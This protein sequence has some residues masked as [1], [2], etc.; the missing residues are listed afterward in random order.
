MAKARPGGKIWPLLTVCAGLVVWLAYGTSATSSLVAAARALAGQGQSLE[1]K[2]IT[3]E[4]APR[5]VIKDQYPSFSAVAI[6]AE[7]NMLVVTD[8][9]LFQILEYDRRANTPPQARLTEPKRIISGPNTRAEMICGVYIDPVTKEVYVLNNDTQN[10]LPVFSRDAR[11]NATPSRYL[12]APHGTFGIAVHEEK[13]EMFLTVQHQNSVYVYR[14]QASGD[15]KPLRVLVG[16]DTQ[17]EDPHGIALDTKNKLIFVSNFGN[18]QVRAPGSSGG[19]RSAGTYGKFELPSITV[20][21][22][23]ASGNTKPLWIIEGSQTMLNWPSHIALHEERQELF[24]ANDA[25]DSILVFR[26]SDKGNVAPVRMIK[27]PHTGIKN[28]P[29]ITLDVKNGEISVASMGTHAVLFFPVTA[30]GDVKPSR[31]IRGGPANQVALN[32]GNPGAVGYD[33]KRDQILVPN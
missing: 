30:N 12:A 6:N 14:K 28:P 33:T 13:Q 15:E 26:A 22:L 11:G 3:I 27:G 10:W 19:R 5:R 2:P 32:I 16:S 7:E 17:L 23:D 8:E 1:R 21:P 29:G 9:N 18:A 4:R 25:D 20:Y 31:I 24:V